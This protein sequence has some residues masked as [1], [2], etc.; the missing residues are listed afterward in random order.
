MICLHGVRP[1]RGVV[2]VDGYETL[3]TPT[4]VL[5]A[6]VSSDHVFNG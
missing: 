1:W 2:Y 3:G 5:L 6:R 4:D